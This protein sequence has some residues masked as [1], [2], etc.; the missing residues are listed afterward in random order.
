MNYDD[1]IKTY[2]NGTVTGELTPVHLKILSPRPLERAEELENVISSRFRYTGPGK[3]AK[4]VRDY[5]KN[6]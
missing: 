4:I 5:A 6:V 1:L 2:K 3:W